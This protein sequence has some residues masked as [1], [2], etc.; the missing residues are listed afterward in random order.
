MKFFTAA[1]AATSLSLAGV[2]SA[3]NSFAGSNLYYAA[4]LSA[5]QRATLLGGMQSAGM[6][7]LR[8]WLD[9]QSTASTKVMITM[10]YGDTNLIEYTASMHS[11]NALSGGD[12]YGKWYG[13]GYF[14]EH[15]DAISGFDNRLRHILN[16]TH[17][18]LGKP[19]KQLNQYIFAFEAQNEAMIGKGEDYINA[20]LSWQC[21]R[22]NTIKSTLGS[23]SGILVMTGGESWMSESVKSAWL[24][25]AALD[26]VAIHAY[27]VG[28]FT[29]SNIQTYVNQAKSAGKK[30]IFQEWGACYFNTENNNC[31]TGTALSTTTR[32]N[33]IKNWA[34]QITA[35]GV[36]WLYWQV[37]PNPDPHYGY[38]FEIGIQDPSWGTLKNAALDALTKPAAFDFTPWLNL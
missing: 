8:V 22:A 23:S 25:C 19:W 34:S 38:D 9:G 21:D 33:N 27:G 3:A 28:D 36:P 26:V 12:I 2:V 11:W 29:T 37:L 30:L 31:P 10:L 20:H 5:S 32:N 7:V 17:K 16:H 18:T 35:A 14:Y 4:G 6:K 13:T 1:I 15:S 24:N